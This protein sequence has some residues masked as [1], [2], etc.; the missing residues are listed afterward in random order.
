MV[1]GWSG[2][3]K[4]EMVSDG[5]KWRKEQVWG[6]RRRRAGGE[7]SLMYNM[8]SLRFLRDGP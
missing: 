2:K 1:T 7:F 3:R 4:E 6:M 5:L 8:L